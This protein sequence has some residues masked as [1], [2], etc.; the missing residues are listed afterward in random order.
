MKQG[1]RLPLAKAIEGPLAAPPGNRLASDRGL[2]GGTYG[3]ASP[4]RSLTPDE[5]AAVAS[6]TGQA[7]APA[8]APRPKK[9]G[10]NRSRDAKQRARQAA[11]KLWEPL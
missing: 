3:S 1:L 5:I 8:R 11:A 9:P 6:E 7:V 2:R 10:R 4:G